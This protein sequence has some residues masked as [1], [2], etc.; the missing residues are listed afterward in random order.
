MFQSNTFK[1]QVVLVTGG[2]S[3]I[4]FQIAKDMLQL[5]AKVII[6]SRKEAPL[7]EAAEKLSEFGVVDYQACDIRN[8]EEIQALA[9]MI[10]E[11]HGRLDVLVNNA[12]GQFPVLAEYLNDKGW[13]AVINNNLNGTFYMIREMANAFFIP[14]KQGNIV[15]IIADMHRGFPGMIHT[16]AARAGVENITKTLAQEWSDFNIRINCVAPG[17]IESSGLDTYP[18]PVQDMFAEAKK[19]IPLKRFGD[20]KDISNAV[21]FLASPLASYITGISL[22]VD[23][24]Q[25]LNYDKMGMPNVL[26]SFLNP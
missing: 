17:I 9:A 19:A 8:T 11:K 25:H 7:K 13:N 22:Y 1:D 16:G 12:G 23:G 18:Q 3:G 20:V 6:C 5:G 21:A 24:A 15:N 10:K 4:G 2:R 14:Q 26:K